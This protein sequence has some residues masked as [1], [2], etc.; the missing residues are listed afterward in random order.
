MGI[1]ALCDSKCANSDTQTQVENVSATPSLGFFILEVLIHKDMLPFKYIYNIYIHQNPM[2][3]FLW[4]LFR[5]FS[6]PIQTLWFVKYWTD[7]MNYFQ[8]KRA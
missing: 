1:L 3:K 5:K 2:V 8:W 4:I 6:S 7:A